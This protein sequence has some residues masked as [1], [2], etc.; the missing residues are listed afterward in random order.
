MI[1]EERWKERLVKSKL[2]RL[3]NCDLWQMIA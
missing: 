1:L 3:E 2:K